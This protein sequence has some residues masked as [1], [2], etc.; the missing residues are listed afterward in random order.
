MLLQFAIKKSLVSRQAKA[1][2]HGA[3]I[4]DVPHQHAAQ[5]GPEDAQVGEERGG[6]EGGGASSSLEAFYLIAG[7]D[8]HVKIM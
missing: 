8:C 2:E 4:G 1:T 5:Q 3:D 6:R 7:A